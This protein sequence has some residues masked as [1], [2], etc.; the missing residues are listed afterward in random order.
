MA[1][2]LPAL[3]EIDI[4]LEKVESNA[5][6][7]IADQIAT[8][9]NM[10]LTPRLPAVVESS[11]V[12]GSPI[13]GIPANAAA[14][15]DRS[16]ALAARI[17]DELEAN[18]DAGN[19]QAKALAKAIVI[20]VEAEQVK[21]LQSDTADLLAKNQTIEINEALGGHAAQVDRAKDAFAFEIEIE[22]LLEKRSD[23]LDDKH[24]G[25]GII[26]N[27]INGF[28]VN[29]TERIL[30]AT[31]I[32]ATQNQ[33]D[34][35]NATANTESASKTNALV[36]RTSNEGTIAANQR[37]IAASAA[38]A[39]YEATLVQ[40][41]SNA[42]TL[43][44]MLSA[45][46]QEMSNIMRGYELVN[47]IQGSEIQRE[48]HQL[49]LQEFAQRSTMHEI[50]A[51]RSIIAERIETLT[52]K[53]AEGT[54]DARIESQLIA[55][56]RDQV[57]LD[58]EVI[59]LT[60]DDATLE[61]RLAAS[62]IARAQA[63]VNLDASGL[64]LEEAEN[65]A[66]DPEV[67][68]AKKAVLAEAIIKSERAKFEFDELQETAGIRQAT[69]EGARESQKLNLLTQERTERIAALL[70]EGRKTEAVA[71]LKQLERDREAR[72]LVEATDATDVQ[73]YQSFI[74]GAHATEDVAVITAR[75]KEG[76]E[77]YVLMRQL[78]ATRGPNNEFILGAS[79]A[80]AEANLTAIE[81]FS[82]GP[83]SNNITGIQILQ[84][85]RSILQ[86]EDAKNPI[87]RQS[88]DDAA[89]AIR[90]NARVIQYQEDNQ[91]ELHPGDSSNPFQPPTIPQMIEL[92][93]P[94]SWKEGDPPAGLGAHPLFSKVL[95][96]NVDTNVDNIVAKSLVA[97]EAGIV[98]LD[99]I[100]DGMVS[101]G[102][103]IAINNNV[104]HHGMAAIGL[105][106]MTE[107]N[108]RVT[109]PR[110]LTSI[111]ITN[112]TSVGDVIPFRNPLH[113]PNKP[114]NFIT[115]DIADQVKVRQYI[116][117]MLASFRFEAQFD[118][119]E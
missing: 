105:P 39:L 2:E 48:R 63:E 89:L 4:G 13:A 102:N 74:F 10:S 46:N 44:S 84:E 112:I 92:S 70:E 71:E 54:A 40:N 56:K 32:E 86:K 21:A 29:R 75:L 79:P 101:M 9:I 94:A 95:K 85:V 22:A 114:A 15:L 30:E 1:H 20:G 67:I 110:V 18:M 7:A 111:F 57:S 81:R 107:V 69:R 23:I 109:K 76:N 28:R 68:A 72:A 3:L 87:I 43:Q 41:R 65:D 115:L 100:V 27:V 34:I 8:K 98:S 116:I 60:I 36:K 26:D 78:A 31:V 52:L 25:I 19:R 37:Q 12:N 96:D 55:A 90:F 119:G 66:V 16:T 61:D 104:N 14:A 99:E 50:A 88:M 5:S 80:K 59:A 33:Q 62:K 93:K 51:R 108:M 91:T 47:S 38:A 49:A 82:G 97:M 64:A 113:D 58:R 117:S 45:S 17:S 103:I 24:V 53:V 11:V 35:A 42:D 83:I 73:A 106:Y 77:F 6:D 118:A